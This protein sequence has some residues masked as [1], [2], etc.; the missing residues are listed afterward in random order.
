MSRFRI[1][2]HLTLEEILDQTRR[3]VP[4]VGSCIPKKPRDAWLGVP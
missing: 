4:C 2:R 1:D 3:L